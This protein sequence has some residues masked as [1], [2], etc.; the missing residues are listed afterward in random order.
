MRGFEKLALWVGALV[1]VAPRLAQTHPAPSNASH[2]LEITVTDENGVAVRSALVLLTAAPPASP[3]HCETD[4]AGH[5]TLAGLPAATFRLR[6]EKEGF[7]AAILP[8]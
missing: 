8:S 6:V 3:L 5:C 1:L 2:K 7:Y 4:F